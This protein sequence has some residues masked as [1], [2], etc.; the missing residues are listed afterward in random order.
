MGSSARAPCACRA[1]RRWPL[2]PQLGWHEVVGTLGEVRGRDPGDS[3]DHLHD[4]LDMRS[5]IGAPVLAI[6]DAKV[7]S[8]LGAWGYGRPG[9]GIALDMLS[10]VHLRV[11]RN[12]RGEPLDSRFQLLRDAGGQPERVRVRRGTRFRAGEVLGYVNRMAHVHLGLG[13]PGYERNPM[14]LSFEGFTD[15][16]APRIGSVELLDA[17]GQ[18]LVQRREG[19]LLVPREALGVGIVVDAWD[20]VDGNQARRRLGL[21]ALG[22]QLLRADGRPVPGF[23]QPRMSINFMRLPADDAAVKLAYAAGSGIT[24]HGSAQTRFLYEITNAVNDGEVAAGRWQTSALPPGDY[25]L[26]IVAL[27]HAG[28]RATRGAEVA[29]RLQ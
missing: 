20:Q 24:V 21:H 4:G 13:A 25:T 28:N 14:E 15:R 9:E 1:R 23:E 6:A 16:Q 8:P 18:R 11:G 19:R 10:Y 27:D 17:A 12:A 5:D 22:F 7:S 26:R 2:W 29:L 3:R